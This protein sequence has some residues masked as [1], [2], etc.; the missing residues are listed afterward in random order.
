MTLPPHSTIKPMASSSSSSLRRWLLLGVII[1]V[2]A[3]IAWFAMRDR[4]QPASPREVAAVPATLVKVARENVPHFLV[5]VGTVQAQ[6]SVTVKS[7]I[8]G[9]LEQIN[10]VEGQDVKAGQVLAQLD[11]RPLRAQLE[12]AQAQ[13][14]RDEAQL[15]NAR[16]DLE[17]Y[18]QLIKEDATSRQALDT[19]RALVAQLQAA[20][21]TDKAQIDYAKVQLG[22]TTITAPLSGRAGAR[23]VDP[24]NIVRAADANGLVVINQIDPIA[25]VFTL[26]GDTVTE[27]NR[28]Q[29][30]KQR[31]AVFAY[32]RGN[33]APLAQGELVLLNNQID[34]AS[35]T[36]QLKARFANPKHL[37]WPGQYVN[38]RLQLREYQD[39]LTV[40]AP[41]VQ[42]AQS[43]TYAYVVGTDGKAQM[44]PID[45]L[46]IQDGKAVVSKGL[47]EG[48]T[49]VLDGQYKIKPGV[50]V[51][52]GPQGKPAGL[53][54]APAKSA[55]SAS[56]SG[57]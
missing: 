14:A 33:D 45:V 26:P 21:Q 5:G 9:Q 54:S 41:V 32:E 36:V 18:Q 3:A 50:R 48:E 40:P 39:A 20:V 27:I 29:Q 38:V 30:G 47:Q 6:A 35:G 16:L 23:L 56:G 25:L 24:G 51:V 17:R 7:R 53:A 1:L 44:R 15:A 43:G 55:A 34:V 31:L 37:L 28:A 46:Q 13:R 8:D 19:Q 22:Y 57:Q 49:V 12:Q 2:L 11:A 42:R 52:S 10:Y 4:S